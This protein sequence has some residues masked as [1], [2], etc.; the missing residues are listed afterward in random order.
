MNPWI[1]LAWIVTV[2]SAA[3]LVAILARVSFRSDRFGRRNRKRTGDAP[4]GFSFSRYQV[5]ERL[6]SPRDVQFLSTQKGFDSRVEA[7][8]KRDS[9]R[10]FRLY[11]RDLTREFFALHAHARSLVVESH[12]PSP[13]FASTLVRQQVAF[14]RAR[15]ALEGRLLL[16]E[17]GIG[18]MS[19]APLLAMMEA[20]R[21]D[22]LRQMPEQAQAL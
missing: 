10:I 20:M 13:E 2:G 21:I 11:L 16:F 4:P 18:S 22:L 17:F 12:T 1:V 3:G 7:Q 19:V 6:L 14:W 15:L 5:M 9:R 8:W